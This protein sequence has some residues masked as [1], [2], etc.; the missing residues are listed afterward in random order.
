MAT[1]EQGRETFTAW[2]Q[3]YEHQHDT[4]IFCWIPLA[5]VIIQ[6][7]YNQTGASMYVCIVI[8][9]SCHSIHN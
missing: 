5:V 7:Y 3:R 1:H 8:K 6:I 4:F 9:K 2:K